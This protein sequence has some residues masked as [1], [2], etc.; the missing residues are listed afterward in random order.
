EDPLTQSAFASIYETPAGDRAALVKRLQTVAFV[1]PYRPAPFVGH[2]A[3]PVLGDEPHIN[4]LGFRDQRETY[5]AK[6]ERTVR[7]FI[8]GGSVAWGSGASSQRQTISYVL[9]RLLNERMSVTTGHRYEVINAAVVA[10]STTQEKLLI[11]QRLIDMHPDVVVMFSGNNDVH[12]Q[13]QG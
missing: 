1:P 2:I 10:W 12:W 3:R 6:P 11:Q 13:L 4:M 7:V 9:E 5:I 8:T